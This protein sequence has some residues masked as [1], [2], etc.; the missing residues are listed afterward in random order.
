MTYEE[1]IQLPTPEFKART[2]KNTA[3][4]DA[5][6]ANRTRDVRV[7]RRRVS[8]DQA[9]QIEADLG[10][11]PAQQSGINRD[12]REKHRKRSLAAN[13][14]GVAVAAPAAVTAATAAAG[15]PPPPV[16]QRRVRPAHA[17]SRFSRRCPIRQRRA[18]AVR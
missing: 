14:A 8:G 13:E 5:A 12:L 7:G 18:L 1:D 3:P 9:R 17:P 16:G 10:V 4:T 6:E 2:Y 11:T 15:L